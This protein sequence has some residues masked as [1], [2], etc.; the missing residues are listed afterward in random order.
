MSSVI[1]PSGPLPPKV[2]WAR[3]LWLLAIIILATS[4]VWWLVSGRGN[5][6]QGGTADLTPTTSTPPGDTS[7]GAHHSAKKH[8]THHKGSGTNK[9][10]KGPDGE[11]STGSNPNA[12]KSPDPTKP[13]HTP[14]ATPTGDCDPADVDLEIDVSDV[15][16]GQPNSATFIFTSTTTPACTLAITPSNMVAR[17]TSG[18][19]VIWSSEECPDALRAKEIVARQDPP[20]SYEFRWNGKR[21]TEDCQPADNLPEPGGYWVQAA[22]IGGEPQRA[23]FDITR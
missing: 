13:T 6:K 16:S 9:H 11:H 10:S 21:S 4:L 12:P 15:K 17:I 1:R 20:S 18:S 14:L 8:R 23:Y 2:Y 5:A 7:A 22:L 3:R 19:D